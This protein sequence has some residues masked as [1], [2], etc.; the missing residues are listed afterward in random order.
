MESRLVGQREVHSDCRW[1]SYR[2]HLRVSA[3]A[4]DRYRKYDTSSLRDLLRVL[5]NK[6]H[7]FRELPE[8]LQAVLGPY[9]EGFMEYFRRR[10]PNLLLHVF[11]FVLTSRCAG[12]P[13][14]QKYL[15]PDGNARDGRSA[16]V[17]WARIPLSTP[18]SSPWPTTTTTTF[19]PPIR[20]APP[21]SVS[22]APKPKPKPQLAASRS[23]RSDW[24]QSPASNASPSPSDA[25]TPTLP[26]PPPPPSLPIRPDQAPC[27]FF[28]KKG[29]CGYGAQCRWNHPPERAVVGYTREGFVLRPSERVCAHYAKT[30]MCAYGRTC[31][32]HHPARS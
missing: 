7:H 10:F 13:V 12:Q 11:Q 16:A 14:F 8:T 5:R 25:S 30:G 19:T 21:T 15:T 2:I 18:A 27:E 6:S 20:F 4:L 32:F 31:V 23:E 29:V 28:V 9:P 17:E 1:V 24:R 3:L 26:P 22:T